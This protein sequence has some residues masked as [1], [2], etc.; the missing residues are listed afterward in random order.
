MLVLF[1]LAKQMLMPLS[2]HRCSRSSKSSILSLTSPVLTS[3]SRLIINRLGRSLINEMAVGSL[4]LYGGLIC[5][6]TWNEQP[7]IHQQ[8]HSSPLSVAV[9]RLAFAF[10]AF[11]KAIQPFVTESVIRLKLNFVPL[12]AS[13]LLLPSLRQKC[14]HTFCVFETNKESR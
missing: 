3:C 7:E 14:S 11:Y 8:L 10:Y 5:V 6:V 4:K 13:D 1:M 9:G 2:L 12:L